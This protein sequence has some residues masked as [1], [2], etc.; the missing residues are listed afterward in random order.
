[1]KMGHERFEVGGLMFE[2]DCSRA[3]NGFCTK[4]IL[5]VGCCK[6]LYGESLLVEEHKR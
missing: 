6:M 1:M 4:V 2:V 3:R 5:M